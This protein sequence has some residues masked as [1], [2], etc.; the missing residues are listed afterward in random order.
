MSEEKETMLQDVDGNEVILPPHSL[1]KTIWSSG[2]QQDDQKE[3]PVVLPNIYQ[4]LSA[5][6]NEVRYIQKRP[7]EKHN[8][9]SH[10][11]VVVAVRDALVTHGVYMHVTTLEHECSVVERKFRSGT[12]EMTL[13]KIKLGVRFVN[14]DA[15][16]DFIWEEFWGY[17]ESA[18]AMCVGSAYSFAVKTLILKTFLIPTGIDEEAVAYKQWETLASQ[19]EAAAIALVEAIDLTHD[20]IKEFAAEHSIP[21]RDIYQWVPGKMKHRVEDMP[22]ADFCRRTR[23][24]IASD[25]INSMLEHPPI[26]Q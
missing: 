12:K 17:G 10:D 11:D 21:M 1:D 9:A 18:D 25:Y 7:G 16:D 26:C 22:S 3:I 6:V 14:V 8:Y 19:E 4:R 23:A 5:V 15:P 24:Y 13:A 20:F 2:L